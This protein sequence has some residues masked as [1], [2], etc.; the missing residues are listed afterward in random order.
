VKI[1]DL[2]RRFTVAPRQEQQLQDQPDGRKGIMSDEEIDSI[3]PTEIRAF[4]QYLMVYAA[5]LDKARRP[6]E[7]EAKKHMRAAGMTVTELFVDAVKRGDIVWFLE[8]IKEGGTSLEVAGQ[9]TAVQQLVNRYWIPYVNSEAPCPVAKA[10]LQVVYNFVAQKHPL[11]D[12]AFGNMLKNKGL[13]IP[14]KD[15]VTIDDQRK[16]GRMVSWKGDPA[17]LADYVAE[18]P[19]L[20]RLRDSRVP[21]PVDDSRMDAA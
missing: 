21:E 8:R 14:A 7:N 10:H 11:G 13:A 6:L 2:D 17:A 4:A 18:F 12:V 20:A 9:K 3:L 19:E 16:S 5:D 15:R 1:E